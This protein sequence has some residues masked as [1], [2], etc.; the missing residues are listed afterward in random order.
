MQ[1]PKSLQNASIPELAVTTLVS[2]IV[3]KVIYLILASSIKLLVV[4]L[5][6]E[7]L[8]LYSKQTINAFIKRTR[9]SS[10][11]SVVEMEMLKL[12]PST[13]TVS[14]EFKECQGEAVLVIGRFLDLKRTQV[15][16]L[17]VDNG[18]KIVKNLSQATLVLVGNIKKSIQVEKALAMGIRVKYIYNKFTQCY[19]SRAN[20]SRVEQQNLHFK[21]FKG[22]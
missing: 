8:K 17:V 21:L 16:E 10:I 2:L 15:E 1:I 18:G 7:T 20:E 9:I 6:Y 13:I 14:N 19:G 5:V 11:E 22:T 12:M 3:F 4:I